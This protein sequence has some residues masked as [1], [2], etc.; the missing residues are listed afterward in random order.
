MAE[1]S[2]SIVD[3][4]YYIEIN[5]GIRTSMVTVLSHDDIREAK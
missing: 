3:N 5:N 2:F 1:T 4:Q